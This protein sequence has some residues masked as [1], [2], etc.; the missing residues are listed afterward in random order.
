MGLLASS[1][2][3]RAVSS[4]IPCKDGAEHAGSGHRFLRARL[5]GVRGCSALCTAGRLSLTWAT[6]LL[7]ATPPRAHV[8][9]LRDGDDRRETTAW[10]VTGVP[11]RSGL[12]QITKQ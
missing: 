9:A 10:G 12:D 1:R 7:G 8:R 2:R 6:A 5:L 4:G 11:R 3:P